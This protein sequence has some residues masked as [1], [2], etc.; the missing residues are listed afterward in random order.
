MGVSA[1]G[2]AGWTQ[3]R[4]ERN[5][6]SPVKTSLHKF[7]KAN[8]GS[9]QR[10][11]TCG[12]AQYVVQTVTK[13]L[14]AFSWLAAR[15]STR[16][17]APPLLLQNVDVP[18]RVDCRF[19]TRIRDLRDRMHAFARFPVIWRPDAAEVAVTDDEEDTITPHT[20]CACLNL[21]IH[22]HDDPSTTAWTLLAE[23]F[24]VHEIVG[25]LHSSAH[26]GIVGSTWKFDLLPQLLLLGIILA[27]VE[28][29]DAASGHVL[30]AKICSAVQQG[31]QTPWQEVNERELHLGEEVF[32]LRHPLDSNEASSD[33]KDFCLL[34]FE[35]L[36]LRV[37]FQNVPAPVLHETLVSVTPG[38]HLSRLLVDRREPKEFAVGM[39]GPEIASGTDHAVVERDG[40]QSVEE[41]VLD[42]SSLLSPVEAL[43]FAPHELHTHPSLDHR[44]EIEGQGIQMRRLHVNA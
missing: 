41:R 30:A 2:P 20:A 1:P 9:R 31:S 21:Q 38:A 26:V 13:E 3:K 4:Q 37:L 5:C 10:F 6:A 7:L 12:R 39:E 16:R 18:T 28:L 42:G 33:D 34:R 24:L 40:V 25:S 44:L 8:F 43:H 32:Q 15:R 36:Q 27:L 19:L 11:T 29:L 14:L 23:G 17:S 22:V 35:H